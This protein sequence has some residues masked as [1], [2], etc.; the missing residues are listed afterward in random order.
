MI[1][2]GNKPVKP[3]L[4]RVLCLEKVI[5]AHGFTGKASPP[6]IVKLYQALKNG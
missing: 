6:K 5:T 2:T 3:I 4:I 1:T